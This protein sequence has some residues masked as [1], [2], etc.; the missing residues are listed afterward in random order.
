MT[1]WS[2]MVVPEGKFVQGNLKAIR[3]E[4]NSVSK[5][6]E[7][8]KEAFNPAIHPWAMQ[9][10]ALVTNAQE[11][12]AE[13]EKSGCK[14]RFV[15]RP[16]RFRF[17]IRFNYQNQYLE[18]GDGC[19]I[20]QSAE[21]QAFSG[22]MVNEAKDVSSLFGR[23]CDTREIHCPDQISRNRFWNSPLPRFSDFQD[24]SH[25]SAQY[26]RNKS[27]ADGN[28]LLGSEAPVE[29][30][31]HSPAPRF[32]RVCL[33]LNKLPTNPR[34]FGSTLHR[35][36][37]LFFNKGYPTPPIPPFT[38]Q[39][40][41]KESGKEQKKQKEYYRTHGQ[42]KYSLYGNFL[43]HFPLSTQ[44]SEKEIKAECARAFLLVAARV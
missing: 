39:L 18:Q 16:D 23:V 1:M 13:V 2:D 14:Y 34:G 11:P 28:A 27:L 24:I 19:L 25:V 9:I 3:F 5:G 41:V 17:S 36:E 7:G 30:V 33:D 20:P 37:F 35:R 8:S 31:R 4:Q 40:F 43:Q 32:V 15:V 12:K 10:G 42:V 29:N 44:I 22:S 6:L 21:A 38:R 26:A